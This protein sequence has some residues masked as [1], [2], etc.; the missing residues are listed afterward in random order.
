VRREVVDPFSFD[1]INPRNINEPHLIKG[2]NK[3]T[4]SE[5]IIFET[6]VFG[7]LF[8]ESS[9]SV[10]ALKNCLASYGVDKISEAWQITSSPTAETIVRYANK[11]E[12]MIDGFGMAVKDPNSIPHLIPGS[13][14]HQLS[15]YIHH[16]P[17][18][19][20]DN[21]KS[22]LGHVGETEI[23]NALNDNGILS[24]FPDQTNQR[25]Y[26][27]YVPNDWLESVTGLSMPSL[28]EG[29]LQVKTVNSTSAVERHFRE[30]LDEGHM[31]PVIA[32]DSV[33]KQLENHQYS[34]YLIPFSKIGA[35]DYN[36][37]AECTKEHVSSIA[38]EQYGDIIKNGIEVNSLNELSSEVVDSFVQLPLLAIVI[39]SSI[40]IYRNHKLVIEGS[41]SLPEGIKNVTKSSVMSVTKGYSVLLASSI[42]KTVVDNVVISMGVAGG[43]TELSADAFDG[44]IGSL[45]DGFDLDDL[46]EIGAEVAPLALAIAPILIA[47]HYSLKGVQIAINKLTYTYHNYKSKIDAKIFNHRTRRARKLQYKL[48]NKFEELSKEFDKIKDKNLDDIHIKIYGPNF[49]NIRKRNEKAYRQYKKYLDDMKK[50]EYLYYFPPI[51]YF[52]VEHANFR[53][54]KAYEQLKEERGELV[55]EYENL[56]F[57]SIVEKGQFVYK[58]HKLLF[59]KIKESPDKL[60][61][62]IAS[63]TVK[64]DIEVE[65]LQEKGV[66]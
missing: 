18:L 43:T 40:A 15:S 13:S 36:T 64:L 17:K 11:S 65:R 9:M 56:C 26:D 41:I 33:V 60:I 45:A 51:H 39:G 53:L 32:P 57:C 58:Y 50:E 19:F 34:D 24:S 30:Y 42:T 8:L 25:G 5:N 10:K 21:F 52:F 48:Y 35:N 16:H 44:V 7:D 2:N 14:L 61:N 27:L 6:V 54:K 3:D 63:L 66:L 55:S 46:S 59:H 47:G 22:F 4:K 29:V 31:I 38:S 28:S 62:D 12:K 37:I 20:D 1:A 49:R 23:A